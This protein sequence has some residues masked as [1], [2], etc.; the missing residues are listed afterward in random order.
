MISRTPQ[1]D[2]AG[3]RRRRKPGSSSSW[4]VYAALIAASVF[5]LLPIFWGLSTS[6]KPLQEISA[7]PPRWIPEAP[8]LNNWLRGVFSGRFVQYLSNTVLV[9]AISLAI[10]T[11][12][13]A[14]AAHAAVR[15]DFRG[16]STILSLMWATIMIPGVAIIVP[17]YTLAV[18]VRVYDTIWVL[19]LV[20]SAWLIPTLT[21]LLRGFVENIPVELEESA[22][23]DGCSRIQAFYRITFPLL[24]PGIVAGGLLV[25]IFI[26]NEFILGYSL[27]LSD[28]NRMVQVGVY[29][30]VTEIGIDW[31]PLMAAAL[32]STIPIV[33]AYAL[34][35]RAFIQGLTG[36]AVKG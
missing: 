32:G 5:A 8:T 7:F 2:R 3:R 25:F 23:I 18:D 10:C 15:F 13:A 27:V 19:V 20:Y 12:F 26:W 16:K 28:K 17:L 4:L 11:L 31:G 36:G 34:M 6:L 9:V 1:P 21:W 33:V 30:F 29:F 35:Q 14:H 22:R 24:G